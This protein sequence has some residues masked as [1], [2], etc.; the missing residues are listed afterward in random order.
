MKSKM[1]KLGLTWRNPIEL[2]EVK[3][4]TPESIQQI[5]ALSKQTGDYTSLSKVYLKVLAL[6]LNLEKE[7]CVNLDRIQ[8]SSKWMIWLGN[9]E[10]LKHGNENEETRKI[11]IQH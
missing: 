4:P 5:I 1:V 2:G 11:R 10:S 7:G 3:S 6:A 9:M 8:T